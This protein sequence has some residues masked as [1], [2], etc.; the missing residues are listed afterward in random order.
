MRRL[1]FTANFVLSS[2]IVVNLMIEPLGSFET[3]VLTRATRRKILE[4]GILHSHSREDLKSFIK[5]CV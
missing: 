2:Q 4:D 3:S 1:L 5:N